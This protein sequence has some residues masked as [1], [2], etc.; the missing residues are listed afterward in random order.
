MTMEGRIKLLDFG[1]AKSACASSAGDVEG[2]RG[3][4]T[5]TLP[6]M[7]PEQAVGDQV[8]A[9][10]DIFS[11]GVVLYEM[12]SGRRPF[13]GSGIATIIDRIVNVTPDPIGKVNPCVP[14][15]VQNIVSRCL[16]KRAA[17]RYQK[18]SDLRKDLTVAALAIE[19]GGR[20]QKGTFS[21][22]TDAVVGETMSLSVF[23]RHA[24]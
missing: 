18:A 4:L 2:G 3:T 12:L 19:S 11:V 5:G 23:R 8:D 14:V 22:S 7:S 6:Y 9:P 20:R 1:I 13:R 15:L 21:K 16:E 17:N 10:S 24:S